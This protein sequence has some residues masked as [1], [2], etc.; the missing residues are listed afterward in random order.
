MRR[1]VITGL[2]TVNPLG[3]DVESTW[4]ALAKGVNGVGAVTRFDASTYPTKVAGEV[5]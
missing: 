4:D 1:I 2:G 5:K 3:N